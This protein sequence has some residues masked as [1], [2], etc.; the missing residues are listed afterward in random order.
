MQK[1][2][3]SL[4]VII[5]LA[6]VL[7]LWQLGIVPV[8]VSHDEMGYIYNAY[9]ISQTGR[10]VFGEH[11]PFLTWLNQGGWPFLPVP[12]YFSAPF[13]WIFGLSAITGR[14][15]A[16]LLGIIDVFLLYILIKQIFNKSSLAL[17]ASFFLAISP[18][19]LHF[20]RS[21][22]DPNF[23]LFFYLLSIVVF[24]YEIKKKK[25]PII[26]IVFFWLAIFSYR[27]TNILFLP[28][29]LLLIWYGLKIKINRQQIVV[30][31][32]GVL[33][34]ICSLVVVI[35]Q[36]G[37]KYTAEVS[38][39]LNNPKMQEDID[40]WSREAQ[41]PLFL[42]RL[43]LNKPMY[44][45]NTLRENYIKAYSP[46]FLF[47]YT[48]PSKIYSIWSRGRIYF[49]DL[50]FVL[51]GIAYLYKINKSAASFIVAL[52][53]IGGFPG[54]VGGSPYS[55]RNFFTSAF[56]PVLSASGV[57]FLIQYASVKQV[58]IGIIAVLSI[59]YLYV[60]SGY[61]FDYYGRYAFYGGEAWNKSLKD[62]S[63]VIIDNK[64]KYDKIIVDS[65]SFGD[66]LQYTFYAKINPRI[67][68]K[69][70]KEK[71]NEYKG[72]FSFENIVFAQGC[73]DSTKEQLFPFKN[74]RKVLYI[75]H[76]NCHTLLKQK[77]I[78]KD[79]FGNTIWKVYEQ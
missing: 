33:F 42:K 13:F 49:L 46:E 44:I 72:S 12:I 10:N 57:L 61:L 4:L 77:G 75:T 67:V 37:S 23:A 60:V 3:W 18:W 30:F 70:W 1:L 19:H 69:T 47:L 5:I 63:L 53:L 6:S 21:A 17:L 27:A 29:V 31:L 7:R 35:H 28:L 65:T 22:Y 26:S 68:Q 15:S 71:T 36:N 45:I 58:K 43:F 79:Y 25:L 8:G 54:M 55:A 38:S 73:V 66:F 59:A 64:Q 56:L 50:V 40:A 39:L 11:L 52:I 2:H 20:S 9:S 48:E 62:I 34:I 74:Y 51:L 76:E 14:L 32:F 16:A 41:G 24:I 78:I